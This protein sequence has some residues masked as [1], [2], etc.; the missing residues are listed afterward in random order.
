MRPLKILF[1]TEGFPPQVGGVPISSSRLANALANNGHQVHVFNI[2]A[3]GVPGEVR[4]QRE[5][6]LTVHRLVSAGG[7]ETSLQMADDVI[8]HI[9]ADVGF[10]IFHGHY[11]VPIGYLAAYLARRYGAKSYVSARGN[12][13]D[14]GM[15]V[16]S[17]LSSLL[18]T[19]RHADAVGCVS[20][21]LAE[22]CRALVP[23]EGIHYT[24]NSV[25]CGLFRPQPKD[26]QLLGKLGWKEE[27]V[28]GFV[29]ELRFKKGFRHVLDA[30]R[31]VRQ[32]RPAK[33]LLVGGVS[34]DQKGF[35]RKYQ[36]QYPDLDADLRIVEYTH[37]REDLVR[38]Y[39]LMDIVLSPSLWDGMPNSVLEAMA[40][41][42]PVI[43]SDAGGIRDV[44]RDGESGVV[45][46]TREL[47]RLG[48]R[49]LELLE[50]GEARRQELGHR[51]RAHVLE[52]HAPAAETDR[53]LSLYQ[54]LIE[55]P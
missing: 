42:R 7:S 20:R 41:A 30:F 46:P 28:V 26:Q 34:P 53:L 17:Q 12:D 54:T 3:D 24:P 4:T 43:A 25:D 52:H 5:G 9:Q 10:D 18:W 35:L 37:D 32:R 21:E 36:Q 13:V 33:L 2:Y 47:H 48:A 39:N 16:E 45:I 23:R 1:I 40:C 14:R 11:L 38:Y 27:A 19:L 15:F 31:E 29:G 50:A 22:K 51:A 44:M 55:G 8:R 6:L 49:C